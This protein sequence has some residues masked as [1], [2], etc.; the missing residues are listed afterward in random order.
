MQACWR[1]QEEATQ[2]GACGIA[3]LLVRAL[4]DL[5]IVERSRTRTGFDYWLGHSE[6]DEV[7]FQGKTRLEVSGIRRG[8]L[9]QISRR[10]REKLE[11]LARGEGRGLG[12][13]LPA[14]VVVV[15]FGTPRS[16]IVAR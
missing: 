4:T 5:V 13:H 7:L 10:E 3:A 14:V 15:E 9:G 2:F 12:R 8:T 16:K 11:Q 6:G 1:N